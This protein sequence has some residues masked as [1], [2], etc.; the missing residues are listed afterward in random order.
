MQYQWFVLRHITSL[1]LLLS[2]V[3]IWSKDTSFQY[4]DLV[5]ELWQIQRGLTF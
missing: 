3:L 1:L 2:V 5:L 4:L